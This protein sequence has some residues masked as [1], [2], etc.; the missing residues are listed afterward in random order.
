MIVAIQ[1]GAN[2]S[3]NSSMSMSQCY[4]KNFT[5]N[6]NK[7]SS[8]NYLMTVSGNLYS[9]EKWRDEYVGD[10]EFVVGYTLIYP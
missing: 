3:C 5:F 2:E 9:I 1:T 10:Y 6:G 7:S 8:G 4:Q